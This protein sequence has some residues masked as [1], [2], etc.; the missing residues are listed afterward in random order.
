M[1]RVSPATEVALIVRGTGVALELQRQK[2]EVAVQK[3]STTNKHRDQ[4]LVV[5]FSRSIIASAIES[6][7]LPKSR[8]PLVIKMIDRMLWLFDDL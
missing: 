5:G 3:N 2:L 1:I 7:R 6:M 4:P 8:K